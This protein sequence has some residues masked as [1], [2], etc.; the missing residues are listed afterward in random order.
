MKPPSK[1]TLTLSAG[2]KI[3]IK[4]KKKAKFWQKDNTGQYINI[5]KSGFTHISKCY[6]ER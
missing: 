5:F 4:N 1:F 2:F 6:V 3:K